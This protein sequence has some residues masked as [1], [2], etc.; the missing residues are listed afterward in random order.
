[1]L[2]KKG[3]VNSTAENNGLVW[4]KGSRSWDATID[5]DGKD[6]IVKYVTKDCSE[7][8]ELVA[9]FNKINLIRSAYGY[10]FLNVS[11][12]CNE[13]INKTL[14]L[15]L[16]IVTPYFIRFIFKSDYLGIRHRVYVEHNYKEFRKFYINDISC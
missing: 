8:S 11:L 7:P 2:C 9:K 4:N 6:V 12:S 3:T 15:Q 1:M 16:V 13:E 14:H 10:A 5:D